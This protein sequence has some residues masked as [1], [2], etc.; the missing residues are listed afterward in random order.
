MIEEICPICLSEMEKVT[1][2]YCK[3]QFCSTC[4]KKS[5][6]Y[7]NTC[8]VCRSI[9]VPSRDE[10]PN[11]VDQLADVRFVYTGAHRRVNRVDDDWTIA[12]LP[13]EYRRRRRFRFV[14]IEEDD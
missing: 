6:E 13:Q 12:F 8:P 9:L 2:T 1:T 3:H 4:I 7:S 10:Q 14:F 11:R 5:L